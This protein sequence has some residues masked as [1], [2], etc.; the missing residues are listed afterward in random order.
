VTQIIAQV[1]GPA[2]SAA[3]AVASCESHLDP[4]AHNAS[5][6]SGLFQLMPTWWAG[7][8]DPYNPVV[9]TRLAHNLY[10]ASG[11]SNWTCQP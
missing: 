1:F 11:W 10:L 7:R 2:A 3:I 8:Y 9:N 4:N 6:A 5:G